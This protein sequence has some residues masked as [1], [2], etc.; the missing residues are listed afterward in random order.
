MANLVF[1]NQKQ[2]LHNKS[3]DNKTSRLSGPFSTQTWS[4][5]E[6][7]NFETKWAALYYNPS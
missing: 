7:A 5:V 3:F 2:G 6:W 1:F 4:R